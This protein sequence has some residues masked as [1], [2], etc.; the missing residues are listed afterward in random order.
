MVFCFSLS[1]HH[2]S[3]DEDESRDWE[4]VG[5]IYPQQRLT[6][7][8]G[9]SHLNTLQVSGWPFG[10]QVSL[11][12]VYDDETDQIEHLDAIP[13]DALKIVKTNEEDVFKL[14][15]QDQELFFKVERL[16]V[17]DSKINSN[18]VDNTFNKNNNVSMVNDYAD[19]VHQGQNNLSELKK[20]Q[21]ETWYGGVSDMSLPHLDIVAI[22]L[23]RSST[24]VKAGFDKW[25]ISVN[26]LA[27]VSRPNRL[28][29]GGDENEQDSQS[30]LEHQATIHINQN[31]EI[32]INET[33]RD[34]RILKKNDSFASEGKEFQLTDVPELLKNDYLSFLMLPSSYPLLI[35]SKS[36]ILG[37]D[38]MADI[39]LNW[40]A[41]DSLNLSRKHLSL[42]LHDQ[43]LE[44]ELLST[45]QDCFHL[46]TFLL[47]KNKLS[48]GLSS[49]KVVVSDAEYLLLGNYLLKVRL[50]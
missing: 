43:Q 9:D 50:G 4:L 29:D 6:L 2:P 46:D 12:L 3:D 47:F 27:L 14:F 16:D 19:G 38:P 20:H 5:Y 33:D 49:H 45:S 44:V 7:I 48:A 1:I 22:A 13:E 35:K 42:S 24:F 32:L 39:S 28:I 37:R 8:N 40:F 26:Q 10:T 21:S 34:S 41:Q 30:T 15:A 25:E 18:G 11:L 31:D 36:I 23:P 17:T